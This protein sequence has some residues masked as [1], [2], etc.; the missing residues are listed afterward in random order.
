[1][2]T[3]KKF[4]VVGTAINPKGELKVRWAN[5]LV[6]RINTLLKAKCEDINLHEMPE[7]M[8]KLEAI[9]WLLA[10][11]ELTPEQDEVVTLKLREK[12]KET[13]VTAK[14]KSVETTITEN[15]NNDAKENNPVDPRVAE[16][17]SKEL[18]QSDEH[19]E[20]N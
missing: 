18:A 14:R 10:N 7:P 15:I 3:E 6:L 9:K 2:S 17:I 11:T 19:T 12:S 20:A 5:D 16:F 1:M 4:T 13:R 8:T